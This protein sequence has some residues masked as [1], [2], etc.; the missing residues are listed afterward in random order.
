MDLAPRV[1][2]VHLASLVWCIWPHLCGASGLTCVVHLAS[3][4]WCTW[5]HLCGA[6][7]L[8]CVVH[9]A[10]LVWCIWP[11]LCG[12]SGLTCVVHLAPQVGVVELTQPVG[13]AWHNWCGRGAAL[14]HKIPFQCVT[15]SVLLHASGMSPLP[16]PP[17][18][19]HTFHPRWAFRPPAVPAQLQAGFTSGR[20]D[21]TYHQPGLE[22]HKP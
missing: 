8:T 10:S 20:A 5:P 16:P 15:F 3:L 2:V 4:V 13:R 6:S 21:V 17:L 1:C 12:A 22:W 7:G 11:H 18:L 9:L 14:A 19:H